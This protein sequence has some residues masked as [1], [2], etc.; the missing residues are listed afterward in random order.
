MTAEYARLFN[1]RFPC[2]THN[3][4]RPS[5]DAGEDSEAAWLENIVGASKEHGRAWDRVEPIESGALVVQFDD[6]LGSA[7]RPA[8]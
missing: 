7:R 6:A 5:T 8:R 2:S 3:R 4:D 1:E